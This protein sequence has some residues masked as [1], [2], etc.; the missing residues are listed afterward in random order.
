VA[1]VV[2]A[3]A[4]LGVAGEARRVGVV[5]VGGGPLGLDQGT[6][7][8]AVDVAAGVV[9]FAEVV[10]VADAVLVGVVRF[11]QTRIPGAGVAGV[12]VAVAVGVGLIG[13][14]GDTAVVDV[15][16]DA[17]L[18]PVADRIDAGFVVG[19]GAAAVDG[20]PE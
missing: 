17:V 5:A 10:G 6:D 11:E 20:A 18:V 12:A 3:V 13:V 7:A 9:A 4:D 19:E 16:G 2:E 8:V 14:G 15:V 1:V